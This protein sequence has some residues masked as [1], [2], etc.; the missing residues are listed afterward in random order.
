MYPVVSGN[1][2]T[3]WAIIRRVRVRNWHL[4]MSAGGMDIDPVYGG[5][6]IIKGRPRGTVTN[7]GW[8][9]RMTK[10][11]PDGRWIEFVPQ[12][13]T[14][15]P[16][17]RQHDSFNVLTYIVIGLEP[18]TTYGYQIVDPGPDIRALGFPMN[19]SNPFYLNFLNLA[20]TGYEMGRFVMPSASTND[21]DVFFGMSSCNGAGA[22]WAPVLAD[23]HRLPMMSYFLHMGDFIYAD[24]TIEPQI[25]GP[26]DT[27]DH[28]LTTRTQLNELYDEVW[29]TP[30]MRQLSTATG[31]YASPD[32]HEVVN[33]WE[34]RPLISSGA[35]TSNASEAAVYLA[36]TNSTTFPINRGYLV[37]R[38][39]GTPTNPAPWP[40]VP[41][42]L[43]LLAYEELDRRVASR[44][45]S[46]M[47]DNRRYFK[48]H[49]GCTDLF[50]I[51]REPV[52]DLVARTIY[53]Q[54]NDGLFWPADQIAWLKQELL[55]STALV[56]VVASGY[57]FALFR[58][59]FDTYKAKYIELAVN[60][61][62]GVDIAEASFAKVLLYWQ[63]QFSDYYKA[64]LNDITTFI[65]ENNIKNVI[66]VGGGD[67]SSYV[68]YANLTSPVLNI[69][70]GS[71]GT[72]PGRN[73]PLV[74]SSW[75]NGRVLAAATLNN[76]VT[77][78][79]QCACKTATIVS[80]SGTEEY[81]DVSIKLD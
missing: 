23:L 13:D 7:P 64:Q 33:D 75:D 5:T 69:Q 12:T 41:D 22:V 19:L 44:P 74:E 63:A 38:Y 8:L 36:L 32:D 68:V 53:Y 56:K 37:Y 24:Q 43:A 14:S 65:T 48:Q 15:T 51:D 57:D 40:A 26:F 1:G 49:W 35:A 6:V 21:R 77:V 58:S 52:V 55:A 17:P 9:L 72:R 66:S 25:E 67:H 27:A 28:E 78:H 61:G 45:W 73:I 10:L 31:M 16:N 54:I 34:A 79:V 30:A 42:Y 47:R 70:A 39:I 76:Y 4:G 29:R 11:Q 20:N 59:Y 80:R 60:A 62:F 18:D 71:L 81:F 3:V 2:N 46:A 50:M